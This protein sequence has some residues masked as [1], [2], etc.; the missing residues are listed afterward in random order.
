[1]H[2][3]TRHLGDYAKD[4]GHLSLIEHGAYTVL[5]DWS[6]ASE[7]ALPVSEDEVFRICRAFKKPEQE[8]VRRVLTEFFPERQNP[9]AVLVIQQFN[10]FR[11][12]NSQNAKK[13]WDKVKA[14]TSPALPPHSDGDAPGMRPHTDGTANGMPPIS[15]L[16]ITISQEPVLPPP[17]PLHGGGGSPPE[18]GDFAEIPSV[19]EVYAHASVWAGDLVRGVPPFPADWIPEFLKKMDGRREWPLRWKRAMESEWRAV[20]RG[21]GQK[22]GAG[23]GQVSASVAAVGEQRVL[24]ALKD[25]LFEVGAWLDAVDGQVPSEEALEKRRREKV[26]RRE[27]AD[28]EGTGN[29][30]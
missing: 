29:D 12:E 4:T 21:W 20:C 13:R 16:P 11:E 5:L 9:R 25:E 17:G 24:R 18:L 19:D 2:Y 7:R 1:M 6:Y 23:N 28:M 14:R 3:Y 22:N 27:I 10:H 15:H 30:Q 8:A 26:L